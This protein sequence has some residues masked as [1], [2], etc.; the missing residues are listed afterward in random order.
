MSKTK[1]D[2]KPA[3]QAAGVGVEI[4][5]SRPVTHN[6]GVG[7]EVTRSFNQWRAG[8]VVRISEGDAEWDGY[9]LAGNARYMATAELSSR[10]VMDDPED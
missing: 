7:V 5:D 10:P 2:S 6:A 3:A 8:D 4:S 9:V 1:S